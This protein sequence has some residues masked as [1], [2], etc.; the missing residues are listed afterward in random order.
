M[1]IK[2]YPENPSPRHI[3]M[4]IDVLK[5]GGI[6]IYPTDTVYAIGC[7][8]NNRDA[9]DRLCNIIHKKPEKANLSLICCDLSEL[10][11]YTVPFEDKIFRMMRRSLPGPYTFILEANSKV[12]K[13]F[14]NK[15]KTVG[16]R[17]PDNSIITSLVREFGNPLVSASIHANREEDDYYI[18]PEEI[19]DEFKNKVDIVIDGGF[20]DVLV[21]TVLDCSTGEIIL[22]REGK[23][24]VEVVEE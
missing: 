9:I 14:K 19:Y 11:R 24:V 7:D 2:I 6:I 5:K 4:V 16:I 12:P 8:M 17:V 20:G 21:S 10:S 1:L 3:Q 22:M 15:K 13:L 23:G 18:D